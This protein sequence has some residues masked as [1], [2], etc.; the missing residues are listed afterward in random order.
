[1]SRKGFLKI[2]AAAGTAGVLTRF[3]LHTNR[4]PHV[5]QDT[6][7][8]MGTIVNL[9]VVGEDPASARN[10]VEACFSKMQ[11]LES[12]LSR[13]DSHSQLSRLNQQNQ[14]ASP[15]P[16]LVEIIQQAKRISEQ[17]DGSFDITV[18]PLLDLYQHAQRQQN[19][20]PS[21]SDVEE[22]LALIDYHRVFVEGD[23]L[24]LPDPD[25]ALTLDGIAKGFI[26]DR[27]VKILRDC[28]YD[29]VLVEAG[30]DLA[31]FG[32]NAR[33]SAWRVGLKSPRQEGGAFLAAVNVRNQALAT[34]GDYQTYYSD[35]YRHHHI[36]DPR[37]GISPAR[38]ASVSILAPS[39]MLADGYA[40]AVMVLGPERGKKLV[41]SLSGVEALMITKDMQIIKTPGFQIA[42]R[43]AV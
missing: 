15:D 33:Q 12:V 18:K 37:R 36:L 30:G 31:A 35:D 17:S 34:S 21:G 25:M 14:I 38:L 8:M 32:R 4:R 42:G 20:L 9:T 11:Y 2:V 39:A 27:G 1:M 3:G 28:G 13:H 5:V 6:R 26:V 22:R 41:N 23:N 43:P 7:V 16:A 10:A 40:T 24:Q 19:V 29:S